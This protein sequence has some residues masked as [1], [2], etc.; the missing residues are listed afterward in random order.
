MGVFEMDC[1]NSLAMTKK[2]KAN[3]RFKQ[4]G[5]KK[6]PAKPVRTR[7]VDSATLRRMTGVLRLLLFKFRSRK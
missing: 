2:F 6:P 1:F 5:T 7:R 4:N 3:P